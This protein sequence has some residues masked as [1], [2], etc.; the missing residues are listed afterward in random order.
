MAEATVVAAVR[1]VAA[2]ADSTAVEVVDLMVAEA[3]AIVAVVAVLIVPEAVATIAAP[4]LALM[5]AAADTDMQ[6]VRMVGIAAM[7]PTA[8][9]VLAQRLLPASISV[10][11]G[12]WRPLPRAE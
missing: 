8:A 10:L 11:A 2:E 3:A 12:R 5:P 4:V 9:T 1:M 7:R 6:I